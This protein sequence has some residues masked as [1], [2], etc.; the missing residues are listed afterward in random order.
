MQVN[1][2]EKLHQWSNKSMLGAFLK[3][4]RMSIELPLSYGVPRTTLKDWVAGRV[5]QGPNFDPQAYLTTEE[6]KELVDF[7]ITSSKMG[8]RRQVFKIVEA[9]VWFSF[10]RMVDPFY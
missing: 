2:P 3:Q 10:P 9:A 1:W 6:E 4:L 5:L 7:L 8:Y